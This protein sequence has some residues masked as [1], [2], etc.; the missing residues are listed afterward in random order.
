MWDKFKSGEFKFTILCTE[1]IMIGV[2]GIARHRLEGA[3][4]AQAALLER[5]RKECNKYT[6]ISGQGPGSIHKVSLLNF[7][8]V[9]RVRLGES[10]SFARFQVSSRRNGQFASAD[11]ILAAVT[12]L[13]VCCRG[14]EPEGGDYF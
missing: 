2:N 7:G 14:G 10:W 5:R 9:S 8:K 4:G 1:T 6:S 13:R 12:V 3:A 11:G